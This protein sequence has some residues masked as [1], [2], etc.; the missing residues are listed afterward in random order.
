M[1]GLLSEA[2]IERSLGVTVNGGEG[3]QR[4]RMPAFLTSECEYDAKGFP[5]L[6]TD[7]TT[8][9]PGKTDQDVL[10]GV[11]TDRTKDGKPVG[12]YER[13]MGLGTLAGFG[14]DATMAGADLN[15]WNLGVVFGINEERLLLTISVT[16][17]ANLAQLQPLADVLLAN[18]H[19]SI[20][21]CG[22]SGC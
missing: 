17:P 14:R 11:F 1:C 20:P 9:Q 8:A 3:T 15:A 5:S 22:R 19:S 12:G 6:S 2:S 10:D 7:L 21:R 4:G 18:L 13:V 16:G